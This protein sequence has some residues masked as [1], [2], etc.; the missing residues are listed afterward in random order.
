MAKLGIHAFCFTPGWEAKNADAELPPLKELG[1][2]VVELPLLRPAEFDAKGTRK[3]FEKHG[4]GV[5]CSLGLP[6]HLDPTRDLKACTDFLDHALNVAAEAGSKIL[7][8][9]TFGSIGKTS[10]GPRTD[11]EYD[12]MCMMISHA[13]STSKSLDLRLG[14]EPCNRYETHLLNTGQQTVEALNRIGADNTFV[15]LDTYHMN[16]EEVSMYQSCLDAGSRLEYIHLS[17]S[18]R[19]VPG[20]GCLK[21]EDTFAGLKAVDFRGTMTL[22]SFIYVDDDIAGGL[23]LWRPVTDQPG[24]ILKV[25]IPFLIEQARAAGIP[26][27]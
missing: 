16:I 23:A 1:I 22:E 10:G 12:A 14:L 21:W 15:H 18:N 9:V 4:M 25:G 5:T 24:D 11:A 20:R 26:I 13:A 27:N 8:G 17:E 7:S 2:G 19:G 3:A 6:H